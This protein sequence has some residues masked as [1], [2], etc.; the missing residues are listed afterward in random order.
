MGCG[1]AKPHDVAHLSGE[2]SMGAEGWLLLD[3][4]ARRAQAMMQ[5]RGP[6]RTTCQFRV[7]S[8][9]SIHYV[10]CALALELPFRHGCRAQREYFR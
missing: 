7:V 10:G 6:P 8:N 5:E 9:V 2:M 3:A 4:Q 1:L